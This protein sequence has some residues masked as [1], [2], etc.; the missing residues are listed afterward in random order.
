MKLAAKVKLLPIDRKA[1]IQTLERAN[2]ACNWIS[3]MAW[4]H[5]NFKQPSLHK[6]VYYEVRQ[7]FEL[8]AQMAVRAI[9]KVVDA[10]KVDKRVMRIFRKHGAFPYDDRILSWNIKARTV[11][12]WTVNGRKTMAYQSGPRQDVLLANR[13]GESD[14]VYHR[15]QFYLAATCNADNPAP[16]DVDDFLGVDLGIAN[17]ASDS[18]GKRYSGSEV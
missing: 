2:E 7:R 11:S 16:S 15:G 3:E 12:I 9:A 18:D 13:Q 8:T 1:L 4:Q 10:Y 6:V 17:I 14:L 5:Q